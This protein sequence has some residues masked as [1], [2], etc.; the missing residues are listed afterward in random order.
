MMPSANVVSFN[1]DIGPLLPIHLERVVAIDRSHT[2]YSRQHF[3]D[4]RFAAAARR[5]DDF[6][7]LGLMRGGA[8]RGFAIAH[9]LRGEF[10]REHD[11]AVLD[12]L[13]VEPQTQERGVGQS[14]IE[15]LLATLRRKGVRSLHSQARW[16]DHDL[17]RFFKASGFELSPRFLLERSVAEPLIEMIEEP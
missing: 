14:L 16:T 1:Q 15:E 7:L 17:L 13:G 8:L 11:V 5:P 12:A 2:G 4:K 9:V 10:G 6:V 3:F